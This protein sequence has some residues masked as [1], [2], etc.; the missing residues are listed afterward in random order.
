MRA[1]GLDRRVTLQRFTVTTDDYGEEIQT[2][3]DLATVFAEVRQQSGREFIAAAQVQADRLVVFFIR[4][5][6][7]L[8]VLDRVSYAGTLHD[9]VEVREIGRRDGVELHTVAAV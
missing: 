1:G 5:F 8:T 7:G 3:S 6:S 4:W 2:W 9:I